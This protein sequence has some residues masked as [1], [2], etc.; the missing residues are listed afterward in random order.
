M[1]D[2]WKIDKGLVLHEV[3]WFATLFFAFLALAVLFNGRK[4]RLEIKGV[5]LETGLNFKIFVFNAVFF[6]FLTGYLYAALGSIG[7]LSLFADQLEAYNVWVVGLLCVFVG[8]FVAYFRHRMEH[9]R[10]LWPFHSVHHSD[11]YMAWF[12]LY[13]FHPLNQ[14]V[15]I[16][17]DSAVLI[18]IGFPWWAI[19]FNNRLRHYYGLFIHADLPWSY[20]VLGRIFVSPAMHRWHHVREGQGTGSNFA[21]VF[22]VFDQLFGTYYVPGPCNEPLGISRTPTYSLLENM[23]YPFRDVWGHIRRN[24]TFLRSVK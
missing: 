17:V 19:F 22:S 24:W 2:F 12:S 23:V 11:R 9:S 21:T 6:G 4:L 16:V 14:V 1:V 15:T 18:I 20:G 13:R 8:D 7:S 10:W 5:V 3:L